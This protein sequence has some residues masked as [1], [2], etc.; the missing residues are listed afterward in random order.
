MGSSR[1]PRFTDLDV[2]YL[3]ALSRVVGVLPVLARADTLTAHERQ[4]MRERV[5]AAMAEHTSDMGEE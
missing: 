2:E 1:G 4:Q 3:S 5:A